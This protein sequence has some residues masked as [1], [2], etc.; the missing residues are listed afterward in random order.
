MCENAGYV[1]IVRLTRIKFR[2]S[3]NPH[4]FR[5]CAATS[6]ATEDPAHVHMTRNILGHKKL[7]TSEMHFNHAQSIEALQRLQSRVH[8]LRREGRVHRNSIDRKGD[9]R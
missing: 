8:Q 7:A 3:L 4:L 6:I 2:H 9:F 5:D 1:H